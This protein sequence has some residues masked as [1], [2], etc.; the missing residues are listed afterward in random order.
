MAVYRWF[1][2]AQYG[3]WDE[4]GSATARPMSLT[5]AKEMGTYQTAGGLDCGSWLKLWEEPFPMPSAP[6]CPRCLVLSGPK[7]PLPVGRNLEG[8]EDPRSP[9][10]LRGEAV[11]P[12]SPRPDTTPS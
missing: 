7:S 6:A 12:S 4:E 1:V 8:T 3:A 11:V 9:V 10:D 2:V 5:H